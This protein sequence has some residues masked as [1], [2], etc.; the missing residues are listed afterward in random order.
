MGLTNN[1]LTLEQYL[2]GNPRQCARVLLQPS[3]MKYHAYVQG[4]AGRYEYYVE[5]DI[6][7]QSFKYYKL[8]HHSRLYSAIGNFFEGRHITAGPS[9]FYLENIPYEANNFE[10]HS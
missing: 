10:N 3:D 5:I 8:R 9:V 4:D 2:A 7:G 1:F 6:N